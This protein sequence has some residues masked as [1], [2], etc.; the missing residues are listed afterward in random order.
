MSGVGLNL[1]AADRAIV[2]D[3]DWNPANDSQ[4]VDRC[5]RI[6]QLKDVIIY[7]LISTNGVEDKI[8]QRQVFKSSISHATL[9][10]DQDKIVCY[11][12]I[13][14]FIE[15]LKYDPE[16]QGC[17]TL[18]KLNE[19]NDINQDSTS[20][21]DTPTNRVRK[22]YLENLQIVKGIVNHA[23]LFNGEEELEDMDIEERL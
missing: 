12:S 1:T 11:F 2:L 7:R 22:T 17:D 13:E 16:N 14:K 9:Q 23:T 15:L 10:E 5:Y 4:S 6:G 20:L 21:P 8:Y 18:D 19:H 3:P